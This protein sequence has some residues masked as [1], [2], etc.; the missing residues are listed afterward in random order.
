MYIVYPK[1]P[2]GQSP[3]PLAVNPNSAI[4]QIQIPSPQG[5]LGIIVRC[6]GNRPYT[7]VTLEPVRS[8]V[9]GT[10]YPPSH[11]LYPRYF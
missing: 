1:S 7:L 3:N 11:A 8:L 6:I 5:G 2:C 4:T 10:L 9:L